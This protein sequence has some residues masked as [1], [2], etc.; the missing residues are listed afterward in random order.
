M[1]LPITLFMK[2]DKL[3]ERVMAGL[4]GETE[5]KQGVTGCYAAI[6]GVKA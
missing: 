4:R 2:K 5:A 3:I 1:L 6:E